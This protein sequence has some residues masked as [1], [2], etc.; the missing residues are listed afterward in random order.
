MYVKAAKIIV[1]T[2]FLASDRKLLAKS[3]NYV[4]IS[5]SMPDHL[6]TDI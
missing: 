1:L 4:F 2:F 6:N 3:M 5:S